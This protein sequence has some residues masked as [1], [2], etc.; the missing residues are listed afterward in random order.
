MQSADLFAVIALVAFDRWRRT[1]DDSV[2]PHLF[3]QSAIF[4][5]AA[6]TNSSVIAT[7]AAAVIGALM[8]WV[9]NLASKGILRRIVQLEVE[10][11]ELRCPNSEGGR[12]RCFGADHPLSRDEKPWPPGGLEPTTTAEF[13]PQGQ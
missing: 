6:A 7:L 9:L 5:T 10:L 3:V 8:T 1:V 12:A 13:E 11:A 4:G 2:K